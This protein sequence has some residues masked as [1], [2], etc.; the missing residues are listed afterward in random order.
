[1]CFF[2]IHCN[3]SLPYIAVRDLQR[4]ASVKSLLLVFFCTT[5]SSRVLAREMWQ[6]FE[7]SWKKNTIFNEH[8]VLVDRCRKSF[9]FKVSIAPHKIF[10]PMKHSFCVTIS[11]SVGW[12]IQRSD[13]FRLN[14]VSQG[15]SVHKRVFWRLTSKSMFF[16]TFNFRWTKGSPRNSFS[17][18]IF[19]I[20]PSSPVVFMIRRHWYY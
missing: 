15:K 8:P 16:H 5:N 1:M 13:V 20:I 3:P 12:H 18:S 6:T 17:P 7:N 14:D 9:F 11:H 10:L 2:T 19:F 4:N